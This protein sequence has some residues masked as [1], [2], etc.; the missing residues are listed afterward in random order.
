MMLTEVFQ[1]AIPEFY[2]LIDFY[3]NCMMCL[4]ENMIDFCK[5]SVYIY[6]N[7]GGLG[8]KLLVNSFQSWGLGQEHV[9]YCF[10][11]E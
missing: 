8:R 6:Y 10:T 3:Y 1:I 9:G 7:I 4:D 2:Y 5:S 11:N